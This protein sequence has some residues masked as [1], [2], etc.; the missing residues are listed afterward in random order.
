MDISLKHEDYKFLKNV[1]DNSIEECIEADLALPEYMPEILRIIKSSAE[2]RIVSCKL[3]GERVTVDGICELRMIYTAE[4]G[5]I[6]CFSQA[7]PFTRHCENEIFGGAV[8]VT[9][10]L[11]VSYVNCRATGTKRAEIKC[12]VVIRVS[13]F[14]QD[15]IDIVSLKEKSNIQE[16]T[17]NIKAMSLGC[18]K[19]RQFSMSDSVSLKIP[20]AFVV[21]VGAVANCTDIRKISN[22]IMVKGDAVVD[23][24]Y[25]NADDKTSTEHLKHTLPINQILEFDGMEERFSGDVVLRVVSAEVIQRNESDY[26]EGVFDIS[27]GIDASATMWE[28]KELS[29]ISDAYAVGGSVELEKSPCTFYSHC[30]NISETQII[31]SDVKVSGEGIKAIVNVTGKIISAEANKKDDCLVVSGTIGASLLLKDATGS[32]FCTEKIIDYKY[33]HKGEFAERDVVCVP[34]VVLSAIDCSVNGGNS[35]DV[36]CELRI[37][38]TIFQKRMI[39][40]V[41]NLIPCECTVERK[42][43]AITVYFP[44]EEES[45]WSIARKYNTTVEAIAKENELDGDTTANLSIIF[46]PAV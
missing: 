29:V 44:D 42:I 36:K 14:V 40:V 4:D 43:N 13:A 27:L 11:D 38:G 19:T 21:S 28:E 7:R 45:L 25:V 18:R 34:E 1:N 31:R 33:E 20:A 37:K 32:L 12:G 5:C 39:D 30:A 2:P 24:C 10:E 23:I 8:D 41:T 22:K 26:S 3:V 17:E 15:C 9:A 46:I 6:Y 16:K 35:V